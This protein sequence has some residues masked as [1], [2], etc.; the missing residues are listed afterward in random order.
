MKNL[1][2]IVTF[3]LY[4]ILGIIYKIL[5]LDNMIFSNNILLKLIVFFSILLVSMIVFNYIAT[6]IHESGHLMFGL[7][8]GY[9]FLSFRIGSIFIYKDEINNK[10]KVKKYTMAGTSGQCL[11]IAPD[12]P[13][14]KL[15]Y[16]LYNLGG[17]LLNII[18]AIIFIVLFIFIPN[19][20][21]ANI[22]M[23]IAAHNILL[24]LLNGIPLK[25]PLIDNDGYN[26]YSISKSIN[27]KI[28]FY[29]Q[30]KLIEYTTKLV[31]LKEIDEK[32][33]TNSSDAI[34]S[35]NMEL[36]IEYYKIKRLFDEHRFDDAENLISQI[37][38]NKY[39]VGTYV[40]A[41]ML[42]IIYI[43]LIKGNHELIK[44][45]M[46]KEIEKLLKVKVFNLMI[47]RFQYVYFLLYEQNEQKAQEVREY[48]SKHQHKY[49]YTQEVDSEVEL[50]DIAKLKYEESKSSNL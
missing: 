20:I 29:N 39:L 40:N 23:I 49:P 38:Y 1:G 2:S 4:F 18:F 41:L 50:M 37:V 46:S 32:Y 30:L 24:A 43:Y 15:P 17:S 12:K 25:F 35:S 13:I 8:T 28:A 3:I 5:I 22:F 11:L 26:A 27:A 9:K 21:I 10:I 33:F 36:T 34:L 48:L 6:I 19:K 45:I 31:R 14:E 47:L 42:D 16:V 44:E 7:L